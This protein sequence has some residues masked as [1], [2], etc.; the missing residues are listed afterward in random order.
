M[1][2][3]AFHTGTFEVLTFDS[4]AALAAAAGDLDP[5]AVLL[6]ITYPSGDAGPLV[7]LDLT[8]SVRPALALFV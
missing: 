8:E 5:A 1:S 6:E 7:D 3:T 2:I 4:L